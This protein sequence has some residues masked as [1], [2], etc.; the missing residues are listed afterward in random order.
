MFSKRGISF[1]ILFVICVIMISEKSQARSRNGL[2]FE[3]DAGIAPF[4]YLN[5]NEHNYYPGYEYSKNSFTGVATEFLWGMH[6]NQHHSF[7]IMRASSF[8]NGQELD[9]DYTANP[10]NDTTVNHYPIY[11]TISYNYLQMLSF[12]GL[13]YRYYSQPEMKSLFIEIGIGMIDLIYL[14]GE[15]Y[16]PKIGPGAHLGTGYV[17]KEHLLFKSVFTYGKTNTPWRDTDKSHFKMSFMMG[18]LFF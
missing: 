4:I 14:E 15:Y 12:T 5:R 3:I 2:F 13:F 11:P 18:Y 10:I 17:F 8:Y 7:G 1:I 6:Y 16:N 9:P